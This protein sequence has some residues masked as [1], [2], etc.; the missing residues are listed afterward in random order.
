[1]S[2]GGHEHHKDSLFAYGHNHIWPKSKLSKKKTRII[3]QDDKVVGKYDDNLSS[4]YYTSYGSGLAYERFRMYPCGTE[5]HTYD[6]TKGF[7]DIYLGT[8]LTDHKL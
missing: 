6:H 4:L 5:D 1:L 3:G 7:F 8:M 2:Y